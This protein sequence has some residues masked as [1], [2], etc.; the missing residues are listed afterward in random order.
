MPAEPK[1]RASWL[2]KRVVTA[3]VTTSSAPAWNAHRCKGGQNGI[4]GRV[5]T[6]RLNGR[7]SVHD[8][9][10]SLEP[11]LLRGRAP[12]MHS[13][14]LQDCFDATSSG[15]GDLAVGSAS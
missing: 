5:G 15:D 8:A 11:N 14:R 12:A 7:M 4:G 1:R 13:Q 9:R 3:A 10:K 2:G 6:A